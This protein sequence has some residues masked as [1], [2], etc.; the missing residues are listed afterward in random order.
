M[1]GCIFVE[2][3]G[4]LSYDRAL[5]PSFQLLQGLKERNVIL[6]KTNQSTLSSWEIAAT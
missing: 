6:T 1:L 2:K 3:P 4:T 5:K